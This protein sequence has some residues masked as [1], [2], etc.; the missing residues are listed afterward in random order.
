MLRDLLFR[1]RALFRHHAWEEELNDEVQYHF[2]RE[3]EKL[4]GLGLARQEAL[5]RA[6]LA[7]GGLDQV[8]EECREARGVAAI[9]ATFQDLRYAMRGMRRSPVFTLAALLTLGSGA[10]SVS[11][12]F[13]LGNTLFFRELP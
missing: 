5:S 2:E 1:L 13:T 4:M 11:T 7:L 8:K 9:E 12:V 6:R 3:V 10:A